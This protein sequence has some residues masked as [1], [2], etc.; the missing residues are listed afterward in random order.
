MHQ[1]VCVLATLSMSTFR[2]QLSLFVPEPA[3][4]PVDAVRQAL[5]PQQH[6]LIPAHVTLCR[7]SELDPWPQ[8]HTALARIGAWR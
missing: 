6:A 8:V 7:E 5:D 3:R 1:G 4:G 2:R